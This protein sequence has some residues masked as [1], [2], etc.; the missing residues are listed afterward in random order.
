MCLL[1]PKCVSQRYNIERFRE[2]QQEAIVNMLKGKDVLV[3]QP[4]G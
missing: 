2:M 3:L 4:I 1:L